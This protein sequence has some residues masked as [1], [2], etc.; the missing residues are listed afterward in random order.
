M[1]QSCFCAVWN[2][3][4][5]PVG[6]QGSSSDSSFLGLL[7]SRVVRYSASSSSVI[8][9]PAQNR[10]PACGLWG[11]EH[12]NSKAAQIKLNRTV[13]KRI[14]LLW[15][16]YTANWKTW[17]QHRKKL[18]LRKIALPYSFLGKKKLIKGRNSDA[19]SSLN[20]IT[21]AGA[22][23]SIPTGEFLA[24]TTV[25]VTIFMQRKKKVEKSLD[26]VSWNNMDI[27]LVPSQWL[28][29][30]LEHEVIDLLWN[31]SIWCTYLWVFTPSV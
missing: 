29:H 28:A 15:D 25:C 10:A 21:V 11:W 22:W 18:I 14:W 19:D 2:A 1:K 13:Q 31:C 3:N 9:S 27:A 23:A 7:H 26:L 5:V 17:S 6:S 12:K 4:P 8:C 24:Q 30:A 20:N 16:I